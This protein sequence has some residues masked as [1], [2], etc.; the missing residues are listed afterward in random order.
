MI[1]FYIGCLFYFIA[2]HFIQFI[3][4]VTVV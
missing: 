1:F 2:H 3:A 4:T